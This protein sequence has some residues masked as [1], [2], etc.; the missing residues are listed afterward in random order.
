MDG[1]KHEDRNEGMDMG[2][3][4][5]S[6]FPAHPYRHL[7]C[8][9]AKPDET[10]KVQKQTT[11]RHSPAALTDYTTHLSESSRSGQGALGLHPT[12]LAQGNE[13]RQWMSS[14]IGV[15]YD[16]VKPTD[17]PVT[18]RDAMELVSFLE[19]YRLYLYLDHGTTARGIHG[20]I[21]LDEP[22][23]RQIAYETVRTIQAMSS[24]VGLPPKP[25]IFPS[26]PDKVGNGL[27]LPYRA[28]E[29]D[30]FGVNPLVDPIEGGM[31]PLPEA[32]EE[33]Y[34]T[35]A[36]DVAAFVEDFR[37]AWTD[38]S[39]ESGR[40]PYN[41]IPVHTYKGAMEVWEKEVERL[42]PEWY[43]GR[44]NYLALGLTA[45]GF[46]SLNVSE[47]RIKKDIE[48]LEVS[49]LS[50]ELE[51]R[52]K[53]VDET[54]NKH[55]TGRRV[56]WKTYYGDAGVEPP[57]PNGVVP[58]KVSKKLM[59]LSKKL[60]TLPWK[61]M[62]GF[63]DWDMLDALIEVG[64]RHGKDHPDGVEVSISYRQLSQVAEVGGL[65]T[66]SKSIGRLNVK[67]FLNKGKSHVKF[68][69]GSLVLQIDRETVEEFEISLEDDANF[70]PF[71]IPRFRWGGGKLGK[72]TR[73]V[74]IH[75]QRLQPCT[76]ADIARAMGRESRSIKNHV[77]KLLGWGLIDYDGDTN[78]Y[79]I[80]SNF[81]ERIKEVFEE[82]G[83][84][85]ARLRQAARIKIQRMSYRFR[86]ISWSEGTDNKPCY[87]KI[88]ESEWGAF[89]G[90]PL[91]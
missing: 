89:S 62:A 84:D 19:Q 59:A 80:V 31:I 26:S 51:N 55:I 44:R 40:T 67:G 43:E 76:R 75:L 58:W 18:I 28:A 16:P 70:P 73:P 30:G 66:I 32:Q 38:D 68:D 33:I 41:P 5:Q 49:S 22:I 6:L 1:N 56:A 64:M 25:E 11:T 3:H 8:T 83:T 60:E 72:L 69:S 77:R 39:Y 71:H 87:S 86:R 45:Y 23:P 21:F 54:I 91:L 50:P 65:S 34:K 24:K 12:F 81:D 52:L 85:R 61:G 88:E 42:R 15:D 74:L 90:T 7:L 47:N 2:K 53:T 63:T 14:W 57:P 27:Y 79:T 46:C 17:A 20:Y 48:M 36:L 78:T 37:G 35:E 9:S 29:K 82:D 10:G 13:K 4:L